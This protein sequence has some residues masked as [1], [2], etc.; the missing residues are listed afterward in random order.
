MGSEYK[1]LALTQ[2]KDLG[3]SCINYNFKGNITYIFKRTNDLIWF[4]VKQRRLL[5]RR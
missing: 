1:S 5:Q 3:I 2:S 4:F